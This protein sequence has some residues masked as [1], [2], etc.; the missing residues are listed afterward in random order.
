MKTKTRRT[1]IRPLNEDEFYL[2]ADEYSMAYRPIMQKDAPD[3]AKDVA[4]EML[5]IEKRFGGITAEAVVQQARDANSA[6]HEHFEWDDTLAAEAHRLAQARVLIASV[7]VRIAE[8]PTREPIRAF[9]H[10]P[11]PNRYESARFAMSDDVKREIVLRRARSELESFRR[12]YA[13]FAELADVFR[14]IEELPAL[15]PQPRL[16]EGATSVSR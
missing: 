12:R 16:E 5:A 4:E 2:D 15:T 1:R 6:L 3:N 7:R 9:V 8:A 13:E 11:S 10:L 14:A